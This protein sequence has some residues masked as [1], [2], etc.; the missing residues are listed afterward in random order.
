MADRFLPDLRA[1]RH[2]SERGGSGVVP[3]QAAAPVHA[4]GAMPTSPT[5]LTMDELWGMLDPRVQARIIERAG[6]IHTRFT[7]EDTPGRVVAVVLGDRGLVMAQPTVNRSGGPATAL[8]QLGAQPGTERSMQVDADTSTER[9]FA[10]TAANAATPV[11]PPLPLPAD[12]AGFLG[13][14]PARVQELV[15]DPFIGTTRDLQCDHYYTTS[16]RGHG[17]GGSTMQTWCY[18][19]DR[20]TVTFAWGTG[21]AVGGSFAQARWRQTCVRFTVARPS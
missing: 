4:P 2:L 17:I 16:S 14:L 6:R 11:R 5:T 12:F 21:F 1:Q 13:N 19:T 10:P 9:H 20:R 18:L 15:Q 3:R 8:T 7:Y